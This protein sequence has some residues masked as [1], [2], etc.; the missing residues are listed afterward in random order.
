MSCPDN[1]EEVCKNQNCAMVS[2]GVSG[3][4]AATPDHE[5]VYTAALEALSKLGDFREGGPPVPG[6][7]DVT[8]EVAKDLQAIAKL[9]KP[10]I[11]LKVKWQHCELVRCSYG[12]LWLRTKMRREWVDKT[13]WIRV[14]V[15]DDLPSGLGTDY[16]GKSVWPPV[17][18]WTPDG[19]LKVVLDA[20]KEKAKKFLEECGNNVQYK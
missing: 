11:W 18:E 9:K 8:T 20:V 12:F 19:W 5:L 3:S 15:P 13:A 7:G 16:A 10:S 14:D 6:T 2:W 17:S 1:C 4:D